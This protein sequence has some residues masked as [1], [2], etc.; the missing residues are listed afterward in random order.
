M[1]EDPGPA[2]DRFVALRA[3][4]TRTTELDISDA[5]EGPGKYVIGAIKYYPYIGS[6]HGLDAWTGAVWADA[7]EFTVAEAQARAWEAH[8]ED[9]LAYMNARMNRIL[10]LFLAAAGGMLGLWICGK[11]L[12][13]RKLTAV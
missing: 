3:G 4:E 12:R 10:L 1:W 6:E 2:R 13:R 8:A 9:Q 5:V 11:F 7:I